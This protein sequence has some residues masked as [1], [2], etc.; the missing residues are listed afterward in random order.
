MMMYLTHLS[1][2]EQE[3][4]V[5]AFLRGMGSTCTKYNLIRQDGASVF[6]SCQCKILVAGYGR[7]SCRKEALKYNLAVQSPDESRM[8][9]GWHK[10]WKS[11]T[12]CC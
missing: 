6:H 4:A 9:P 8:N 10:K 7:G 1:N 12:H 2:K 5:K 3:E 11:I